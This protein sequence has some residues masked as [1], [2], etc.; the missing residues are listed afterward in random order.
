MTETGR[1]E[2]KPTYDPEDWKAVGKLKEYV[3]G[4]EFSFGKWAY[5]HPY[6]LL[7]YTYER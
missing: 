2:R 3:E 4:L 7:Y 6:V 1:I 5:S